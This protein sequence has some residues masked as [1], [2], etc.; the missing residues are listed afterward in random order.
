MESISATDVTVRVKQ[1]GRLDI[2][3]TIME[4]FH[5]RKL[6]YVADKV[7]KSL[8][9]VPNYGYDGRP[10]TTDGRFRLSHA[11][12]NTIGLHAGDAARITYDGRKNRVVVKAAK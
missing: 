5:A 10:L 6:F 11:D 9:I 2:C 12:L 3:K 8:V 7:G 1:D 4:R